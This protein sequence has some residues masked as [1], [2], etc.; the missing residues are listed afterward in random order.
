MFKDAKTIAMVFNT[1]VPNSALIAGGSIRDLLTERDPKDI[2]ILVQWFD[3][4]D[5]QELLI[6]ADR[7][8]YDTV[9]CSGTYDVQDIGD[10]RKVVKLTKDGEMPIDVIFLNC[11]PKERVKAFP[12]TAS[13]VWLNGDTIESTSAFNEFVE[14]RVLLFKYNASKEYINRMVHYYPQ[15]IND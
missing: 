11:T 7:L 13:E 4:R 15:D 2:D 5:D 14:S 1:F 9:D 3:E 6:L 8:G 10:L 12:C